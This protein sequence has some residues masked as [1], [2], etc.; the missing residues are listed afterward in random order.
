MNLY[1]VHTGFYDKETGFGAYEHHTNFF[2]AA[3]SPA[4]AKAQVKA[5]PI[6]K[7][8]KMH[9][10]SIQEIKAVDGFRI[11]LKADNGLNGHSEVT[12]VSYEDI[13]PST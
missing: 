12:S 13:N 4:E 1:L 9:T 5:K 10:D 2:V 6:Y 8:K 11:V 3:A 7:A